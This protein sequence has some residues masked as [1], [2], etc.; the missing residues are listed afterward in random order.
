MKK[1]AYL[2]GITAIGFLAFFYGA[3]VQANETLIIVACAALGFFLLPI[4]FV[5]YELAVES[6]T[7]DGVGETMSCGL[8][9]VT[10]NFFG[11]MVALALQPELAKQTKS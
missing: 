7:A 1:A 4:L 3:T 11:V 8:I 2:I 9:N 5:A 6:T 10:A